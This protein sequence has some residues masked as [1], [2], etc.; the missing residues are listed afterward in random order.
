M[1]FFVVGPEH[2]KGNKSDDAYNG[3]HGDVAYG[4]VRKMH[5]LNIENEKKLDLGLF[6]KYIGM[7]RFL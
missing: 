6:K 5:I 1:A 7:R 3:K 4:P 2:A